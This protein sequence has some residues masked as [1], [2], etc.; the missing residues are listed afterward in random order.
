MAQNI[1]SYY[2]KNAVYVSLFD[3]FHLTQD[4]F[5]IK[6]VQMGSL[7]HLMQVEQINYD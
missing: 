1:L 2:Q 5:H 4:G 3:L 7:Y 6:P